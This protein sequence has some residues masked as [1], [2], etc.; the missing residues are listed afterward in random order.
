LGELQV[1]EVYNG[2]ALMSVLLLQPGFHLTRMGFQWWIL[3][4]DQDAAAMRCSLAPMITSQS[5]VAT[6][7]SAKG[8]VTAKTLCSCAGSSKPEKL[9]ASH[10]KHAISNLEQL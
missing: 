9:K 5:I 3:A 4:W 8:W 2:F 10:A 7:P 1:V 6:S